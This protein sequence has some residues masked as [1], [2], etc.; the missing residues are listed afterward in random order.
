MKLIEVKDKAGREAFYNVPKQLYKH[1]EN[2]VC[3]LDAEIE[4]IF[5]PAENKLFRDGEAIR[6]VLQDDTG[7][8]IGR[9][10]AFYNKEK[11]AKY[12]QPTGGVG[13]FECIH[14]REAAFMLFDAGRDWLKA[15]G[16]E[17]MDGPI[18]FG[19]NLT[20]WG[21]LIEGFSMPAYGMPYNFPY[22]R[23]LFEAYGFK[24]YFEQFT[25]EKDLSVPFPERQVKFSMHLK[26]K[27]RTE[28]FS[29]Q[30]KEKYLADICTIYNKVW[31][32]FHEDYTPLEYE[33]IEKMMRSAR[34]ILNEEFIWFVYDGETPVA[35][36]VVFP[37]ANQILKKLGN[38]KLSFLNILKFL[39]YKHTG[40]ITRA[41]QLLTA[42]IPEY[43]RS[44][45]TG[46]LFLT[47]VDALKKN[48]IK[49]LEMSWVGD[50]NITVNKIYRLLDLPVVRK[51]ITF[52]Y[53]FDR[54]R[55]V[56]RFTNVHTEKY[57]RVIEGPQS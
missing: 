42:V 32:D 45:V 12:E 4:G 3:P 2:W 18:T 48:K 36:V 39:W 8:G 11:S 16:L 31:A 44:G 17:A 56:V 20:Y 15:R 25:Y 35:L 7:K 37:D 1:D 27:Y 23:D 55:E 30:Q 9:I 51:H 33:D 52:R 54:S 19:E 34:S 10:A 43:Q 40:T 57:K 21:L 22:Y 6:W 29:F 26:D 5:N 50:Y 24:T 47:M 28:H 38:G 13:F 46:L 14:D 41:R 53:M 49:V